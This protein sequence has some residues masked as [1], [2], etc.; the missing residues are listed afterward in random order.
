VLTTPSLSCVSATV[1]TAATAAG[2]STPSFLNV[3]QISALVIHHT[4]TRLK[5]AML[6]AA[7]ARV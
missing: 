2:D 5:L 4:P 1:A 7:V 3:R 6:L